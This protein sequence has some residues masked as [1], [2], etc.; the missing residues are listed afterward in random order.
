VGYFGLPDLIST[1]AS[2]T[3]CPPGIEAIAI[4]DYFV[5]T[6]AVCA[7]APETSESAP[8]VTSVRVTPYFGD[9]F[10]DL[11]PAN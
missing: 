10:E 7:K 9:F 3:S 2:A 11:K 4:N 5:A 8:F 6:V 1:E